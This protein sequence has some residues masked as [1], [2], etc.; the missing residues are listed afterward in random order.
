MKVLEIKWLLLPQ[1]A[2]VVLISTIG[3]IISELSD[4]SQINGPEMDLMIASA[5]T[6]KNASFFPFSPFILML[7]ENICYLEWFLSYHMRVHLAF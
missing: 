1:S 2:V 4:I 7:Y 3:V 5:K 6:I